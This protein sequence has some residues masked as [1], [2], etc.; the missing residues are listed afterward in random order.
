MKAWAIDGEDV[1]IIMCVAVEV[2]NNKVKEEEEML[3]M[4]ESWATRMLLAVAAML[5][6]LLSY[7]YKKNCKRKQLMKAK[8]T[9]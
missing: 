4:I 7:A 5:T 9:T 8:F 6:I 2:Q 1:V 3:I